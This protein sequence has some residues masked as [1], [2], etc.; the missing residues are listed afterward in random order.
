MAITN[1]F[2][3]LFDFSTPRSTNYYYNIPWSPSDDKTENLATLGYGIDTTN[4]TR[5]TIQQDDNW[6]V[7]VDYQSGQLQLRIREKSTDYTGLLAYFSANVG[8][9]YVCMG[10]DDV[11]VRYY[12]YYACTRDYQQGQGVCANTQ[13][14]TRFFNDTP[15][16]TYQWSS[17]P[18]IS[19]KNGILSL[20]RVN[21]DSTLTGDDI[22]N[23]PDADLNL[24]D[25]SKMLTMGANVP[26][27]APTPVFY[28]GM[29][30]YAEMTKASAAS[31]ELDFYVGGY[32]AP[33]QTLTNLGPNVFLGF[34]IDDENQAA[35]IVTFR[36]HF[37][38]DIRTGYDLRVH[39]ST[40]DELYNTWLFIHSHRDAEDDPSIND[41]DEGT[42]PTYQPDIAVTGLVKPGYGAI[43][44]G[45]TKMYRMSDAQLRQLS[46][47]LWS[48][49]FVDNVKKFFN[50]PRE[51]IVGLAIMPVVPDTYSEAR[52][53]EAGGIAT[54]V[55]GLL[56][57]DQYKLDTYGSVSV[58]AVKGN[59][60]DYSPYTKVTA[61]LPFVGAHSLDVNDVMG[62]TLTLKY[63]FDFLS[64][65]CVAEIDVDGKP[66]YFFGGSCGIQIP[67]SSED[68]GRMYSSLLSAGATLGST[69]ATVATGGLTAPLAIGAGINMLANGMSSSPTVEY[70]S[71]SG[72]INGM[73]GCKTAFLTI[74]RPIE[75]IGGNQQSFIGRPSYM[76]RRLSRCS[77]YTK[78][79]E[80]H[81]DDIVCTPTEKDMIKQALI[82]GVRIEKH[83][84]ILPDLTPSSA[85]NFVFVFLKNQSESNII[86][87]KLTDAVKVEGKVFAGKDVITPVLL[88]EGNYRDY[89]YMYIPVFDRYYFINKIVAET[90]ANN[91]YNLS[92][93]PLESFKTEI[94]NCNAV[95]ER[96]EQKS[97]N[98]AY[99][100]DAMYWTQV[101][102]EISTIPFLTASGDELVFDIP[103]NNYIL[104]IAGG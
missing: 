41:E 97:N 76:T 60:L 50:D 55:Y 19:G 24:P 86:G 43:N 2:S 90:G 80:A 13:I 101:N 61:H 89:N 57:S 11:A 72:S 62:K 99:F 52:E 59:F 15:L 30:D 78:C 49:N 58:K 87:K 29:V 48:D 45:F 9:C 4:T 44:T 67:T 63:I 96:Q 53:V 32:S 7:Y 40:A 81:V 84:N 22:I 46:A 51:I 25:S 69:L 104:T 79:I 91:T 31:Y 85:N 47:F 68:F 88:F 54:G 56:L 8:N 27:G 36:P 34:I 95:I 73:I 75:K 65:S 23:I 14:I 5:R 66:R 37:E 83:E 17:V 3:R 26:V 28:A 33:F 98:N 18:A 82:D 16:V 6:E 77:G 38:A 21:N 20:A 39:G 42:D 12:Y 92:V 102:K 71:G 74:E 10:Y 94:L 35:K 100:A 1:M 93:D 70:T 64:G 103:S